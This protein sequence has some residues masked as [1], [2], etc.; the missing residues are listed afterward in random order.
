MDVF[1]VI[2]EVNAMTFK[3]LILFVQNRMLLEY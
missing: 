2:Q 3:I 1:T